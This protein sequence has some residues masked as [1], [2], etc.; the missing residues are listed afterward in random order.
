MRGKIDTILK[1]FVMVF[2]MLMGV[3][4]TYAFIWF[5]FD[6]PATKWAIVMLFGLAALSL[7]GFIFWIKEDGNEDEE[8]EV[9]CCKD[10]KYW[11]DFDGFKNCRSINGL[12]A[13]GAEDFCSNGVRKDNV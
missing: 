10:C 5:L 8:T 13:A 11:H 3:F 6:L 9:V 4:F 2:T 7:L 12:D 1:V